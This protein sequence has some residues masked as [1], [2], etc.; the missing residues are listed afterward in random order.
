[1]V[2][3]LCNM[4]LSNNTKIKNLRGIIKKGTVLFLALIAVVLI[5]FTGFLILRANNKSDIE[6]RKLVSQAVD[7]LKSDKKKNANVA[8]KLL[9]KSVSQAESTSIFEAKRLSVCTNYELYNC[10]IGGLKK[11]IANNL[12]TNVYYE[13]RLGDVYRYQKNN[14]EAIA[15]YKLVKGRCQNNPDNCSGVILPELDYFITQLENN[16]PITETR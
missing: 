8:Q 3:T 5:Y 7:L 12:D 11:L 1:M 16:K 14:K 10:A 15:Q 6:A 9:D 2:Y 13:K 4:K